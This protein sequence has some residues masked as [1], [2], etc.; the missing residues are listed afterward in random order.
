M[1]EEMSQ[2]YP[3]IQPAFSLEWRRWL[4]WEEGG[5]GWL[6]AGLV[7]VLAAGVWLVLVAS[8]P[9]PVA[10]VLSLA[11]LAVL[12]PYF[13]PL[14]YQVD[15]SGITVRYSWGGLKKH[16]WTNIEKCEETAKGYAF[17]SRPNPRPQT[18]FL[19]L[20]P[21]PAA[22]ALLKTIIETCRK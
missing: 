9:V 4:L 7:L 16:R 18:F 5:K 3:I 11:F 13:L 14:T 17:T 2:D 6:K 12:F 19:P 8:L 10:G 15:N 21:E 20:P 1:A 22:Q